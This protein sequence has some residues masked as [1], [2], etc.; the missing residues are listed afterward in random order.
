MQ[1]SIDNI[2][3]ID[4]LNVTYMNISSNDGKMIL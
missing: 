2:G 3:Q 4:Q 1:E